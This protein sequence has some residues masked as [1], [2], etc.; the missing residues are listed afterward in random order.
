MTGDRGQKTGG[1]IGGLA[2]KDSEM[3]AE[4]SEVVAGSVDWQPRTVNRQNEKRQ[5]DENVFL[6]RRKRFG[7]ALGRLW[8]DFVDSLAVV[9]L[10]GLQRHDHQ[11]TQGRTEAKGE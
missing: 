11:H 6:K 9:C 10:L 2:A 8:A 1:Q 5:S 4:V 3:V 7:T